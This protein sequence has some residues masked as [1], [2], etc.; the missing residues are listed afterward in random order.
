MWYRRPGCRRGRWR[1]GL[2]SARICIRVKVVPAHAF[3]TFGIKQTLDSTLTIADPQLQHR[4]WAVKSRFTR[5]A[6]GGLLVSV[7]CGSKGFGLPGHQ[8]LLSHENAMVYRIVSAP[9]DETKGEVYRAL[10][11]RDDATV[12]AELFSMWVIE[13]KFVAGRPKWEAA[14]AIFSGEVEKYELVKLRLLNGGHSLI[15]YLGALD[16]RETIQAT[17]TQD[18]ISRF[19]R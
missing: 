12:P 17:R 14:D 15:A 4:S 1:E 10:G 18:F 8:L 16:G 6:G 7:G 13:D 3:R 11:L 5:L 2:W 19:R 9:T